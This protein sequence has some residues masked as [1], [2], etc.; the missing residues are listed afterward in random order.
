MDIIV[1]SV[2]TALAH[3]LLEEGQFDRIVARVKEWENKTISGIEKKAGV[4]DDIQRVGVHVTGWLLNL[5]LELA[6]AYVKK[7]G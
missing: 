6:V 3:L 1:R 2:I 4:L 7:G 5:A